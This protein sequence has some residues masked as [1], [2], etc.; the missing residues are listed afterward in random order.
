WRINARIYRRYGELMELER[1]TF[2]Q[3]T[4]EQRSELLKR[5]AEIERRIVTAKLPPSAAE[6]LYVLRQHIAFVRSRILQET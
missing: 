3:T 4:P 5:L 2:G 6:Q 1:M